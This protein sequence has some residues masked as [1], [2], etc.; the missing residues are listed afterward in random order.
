[1][2]LISEDLK[3]LSGEVKVSDNVVMGY[4]GQTNINRLHP[5]H[6]IE[7]EISISNPMLGATDVRKICG[8]M[9]F[10]GDKAKKKIQYLSGGERSRVLLGKILATPCNLLLL[11]EPTHH[12]DMES[13]E[14][15]VEALD[16]FTGTAIIVTHSELFLR[17]IPF[18]QLIVCRDGSQ[19]VFQGDYDEFLEKQ[20]WED[21]AAPKIVQKNVQ[22]EKRSKEAQII[23]EKEKAL[24]QLQ[25]KIDYL[26]TLISNHEKDSEK[27]SQ[28][29]LEKPNDAELAKKAAQ[30]FENLNQC[31][32]Q[33]EKLHDQY[34]STEEGYDK[35]LKDNS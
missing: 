19:K 28:E 26:E 32:A 34:L 11:D 35:Q 21:E 29:L 13:I 12:L 22:S 16:E 10:S 9:M 25:K 31:V 8:Q 27:L 15:L 18:T 24:K 2:N 30:K 17:E 23:L 7:E 3:P 5:E 20:G 14:A 1:L 6:T 4:F 33:L